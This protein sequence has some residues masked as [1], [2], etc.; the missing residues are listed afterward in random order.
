MLQKAETI[1]ADFKAGL[2]D[3]F[4]FKP[5]IPI[6]VNFGGPENEKC[7]YILWSF[8]N[9]VAIGYIVSRQIWQPCFKVQHK[10]C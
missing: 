5:K 6:W 10:P 9:V 8:G 4:V 2:P 1:P 3:V 7:W